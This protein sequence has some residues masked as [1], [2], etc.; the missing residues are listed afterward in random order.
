MKRLSKEIKIGATF[1]ISIAL[2]YIGVNFLKGSNVFSHDKTYYTIVSNA[3]GVAPSSVIH[4]NGYQVGT[5]TG[6]KYD[7]NA[8]NRIV[9]TLRVNESLRIPQGSRA[10]LINELLGGVSVDLR[11][12]EGTTYYA[13][14]DTIESGTAHGLTGEIEHVMLP[15]INAMMPKIDSLVTS[16]HRIAAAPHISQSL[17][18]AEQLAT[19]LNTTAD[20]LNRLLRHDMPELLSTIQHTGN[21]LEKMTTELSATDYTAMMAQVNNTIDNLH[22]LSETLNSDSG[23]VGRLLNDTAFYNRLNGVCTNAEL[24]IEDIKQH[25]SRYINITIFGKKQP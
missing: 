15:Q 5:V 7:Y 4:V 1:I 20:A 13:E 22:T 8:P 10:Y 6:V 14:G 16:L 2:L 25:P 21:N 17:Q 24:L 12:G 3:S 23:T 18:L 19:K 9:I 11:L